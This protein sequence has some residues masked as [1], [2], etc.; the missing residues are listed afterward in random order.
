VGGWLVTACGWVTIG[1][2][3]SLATKTALAA[4]LQL[5]TRPPADIHTSESAPK[6]APR[7]NRIPATLPP[8]EY[9]SPMGQ[10][11]GAAVLFGN[12]GGVTEAAVSGRGSAGC[13]L[14]RL[15]AGCGWGCWGC[16]VEVIAW[17][18][19]QS[20]SPPQSVLFNLHLIP[21]PLSSGPH[22]VRGGH[23]AAAPKAG[24]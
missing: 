19:R 4:C 15:T 7:L 14:T 5:A 17:C 6:H 23:R 11:T 24:V 10:G 2:F 21:L 1:C 18:H 13:R 9:D 3:G 22:R 12:T 16:N 20:H 8:A